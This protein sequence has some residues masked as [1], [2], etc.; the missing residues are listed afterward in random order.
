MHNT[1][2]ELLK[3]NY[4]YLAFGV[5]PQ[6]LMEALQGLIALGIAGVNVTIPHKQAVIPLLDD[7]SSEARAIGAV[8]TIVNDEGKLSGHNTDVHGFVEMMKSSKTSVEG[9]K[10][11]VLGAGGASRAV[12]YGLMT[13]FR[14]K[15]IYLLNRS[16]ER[17][18]AL[19]RFFASSFGF[20]QIE[21][22]DLYMPESQAVLTQSRLIV[23]TT[24]LGMFPKTKESPITGGH[25]LKKGQIIVD[26]AYNPLETKLI[27][28]AKKRGAKTISGIEMLLHQGARSFE[29]W[30]NQKMPIEKVRRTL[31]TYISRALK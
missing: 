30:T 20:K 4:V 5:Q 23:N 24:P 2:F 21:V 6:Y 26:L 7:L 10:V 18:T 11:S 29:L 15:L 1:A 19:K 22:V 3:M 9:E 14:P 27:R 12:L 8:N 13:Q 31:R 16:V 28:S 25:C 17:A